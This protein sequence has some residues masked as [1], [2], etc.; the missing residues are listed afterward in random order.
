V[1]GRFISADTIVPGMYNPQN[2][3]RYLYALGNPLKYIDPTGHETILCNES[4][5]TNNGNYRKRGNPVPQRAYSA[6]YWIKVI[7]AI[8]GITLSNDTGKSWTQD[9]AML[10]YSSLSN[11]NTALGGQLRSIIGDAKPVFRMGEYTGVGDFY[12]ETE[13]QKPN[14]VFYTEGDAALRQQNIYHEFG[15]VLDNL[16]NLLD[17]FSGALATKNASNPSWLT[18]DGFLD[19]RALIAGDDV[20]DPNYAGGADAY[21][22]PSTDPIEQWGDIFANYVAGNIDTRVGNQRGRDMYNWVTEALT[23]N[24]TAP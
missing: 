18:S 16:P 21:Q 4:C 2:L 9:N 17:V 19:P 5:E 23:T 14:V 13:W 7:K 1:L 10:M 8:F 6:E 22:H 15:H 12:G 24:L 3:N 11:I 20:A